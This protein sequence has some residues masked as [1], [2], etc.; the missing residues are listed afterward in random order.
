MRS[1]A[2]VG[3]SAVRR[4]LLAGALLLLA[5]CG[6]SGSG[7]GSA[8]GAQP[9]NILF[10]IMDDVGVDQMAS[11][12]YGGP[13][14]PAM[15]NI[16][17][18]AAAGVRFRNAWSMPEC[19]PGRAAFFV[20]RFP[21]R[22][23]IY[24]AIGPNDLAQ[25]QV[26]PYD[27]T[28][29]KLLKQAGYQSGM[30]GKFH[31][32]GPDHNA[33]GHGTPAVLG[34][35]HFT[36]WIA[37]VPASIDTTAGG[38]APARTHTCGFVPPAGQ[39][40]GADT[41]AC[42]RPDGT[43]S[44]MSRARPAEDAAGLQCLASG[45]ILV[46]NQACGTPPAGLDFRRENAYYVSPLV[47]IE[48]RRVEQVPLD[49]PRGRGYRTRIE[50]DAAI[51]W[52]KAR[53][54]NRPWMATVSF[55][56]AHTPLQQPP[57][58]L[59]PHSG[60]ADKDALDCNGLLA[61]RV[62]QNQ[63]TEALDTEFGRLLVETG[64][65]RRAGDGALQY[66]PKA[67]NTVI[68]IVGD[69]GSMGFSVKPPFNA[70]RAKGTTYQ[71]GIWDPLIVAGP[72]VAQPGRAVEHMVNMVDVFQ[73]FG[74]LAGI[75]VHKAVPRT[76]DSVALLPY[77]ARPEQAGLRTLNFAQ[78]GFNTQPGG[79]RNGPCVIN[80]ACTQIP[81]TKS[82]CEDNSG[83]WWGKDYTD[84]AVVPNGGQGYAGC[85]QVNQALHRSGQPQVA[86][87]PEF[88]SA[89]RNERYKV[90]RN[91]T[92][93]YDS[94]A[95]SCGPVTT[96]EFYEIDQ[97]APAP[98]LDDADRNLMLAPLSGELRRVYDELTAKLDAMLASEPP[99]AGDGNKDGFVDAEDVANWRAIAAEWGLSSV[100]DFVVDALTRADDGQ[101]ILRNLGTTCP[102]SHG[103]Y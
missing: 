8:A 60:H 86:V 76:V 98:L 83:V 78:S 27:M 7:G 14:P 90:V 11:F 89:L 92:Q 103:Y 80:S 42:Y 37:G 32:A 49:D 1:D 31:L 19:S 85:C 100:Y 61:G 29:P 15:P 50:A 97:A 59:V 21:H 17:A 26:S 47:V 44:V 99:C 10:V 25:S 40:G 9:P 102:K 28:V 23:N 57:R 82:V 52:I 46:P 2:S 94:A 77:L 41:G 87:L 67:N 43:C 96:N 63:M 70:Q 88:S 56:A 36:G 51:A 93:V 69:N 95:D 54:S 45:G 48:G 22:T 16:D 5:S 84:P 4:L 18:V 64:L 68:V 30:F 35:D 66:D 74:E 24:Q 6:G 3:S 62:L 33:A 101:A 72:Q 53:P 12:G 20:G 73:L 39:P 91:T 71:T 81:M 55:S 79:G 65:A 38:V 34:W 75:D 58:A 13:V